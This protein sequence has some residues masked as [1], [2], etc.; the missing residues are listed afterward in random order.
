VEFDLLKL[1]EVGNLD[2]RRPFRSEE[3]KLQN[4]GVLRHAVVTWAHA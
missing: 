3:D 4:F 2:K 1:T